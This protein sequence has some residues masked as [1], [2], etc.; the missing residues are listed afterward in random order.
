MYTLV[1]VYK[2]KSFILTTLSLITH[3][4][5]VKFTR[6]SALV[7]LAL[8]YYPYRVVSILASDDNTGVLF[9][10]LGVGSPIAV[11]AVWEDLIQR[12]L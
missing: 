12:Y 11:T 7:M 6:E 9:S 1:H 5:S 4:F 2:H 10:S 8:Y 3:G